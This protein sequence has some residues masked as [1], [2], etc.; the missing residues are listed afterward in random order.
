MLG[1]VIGSC[2]VHCVL[3]RRK[4]LSLVGNLYPF[5]AQFILY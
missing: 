5:R 3:F 4:L 1:E 2:P